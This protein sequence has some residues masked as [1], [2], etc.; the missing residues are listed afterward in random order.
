MNPFDH[1]EEMFD[2]SEFEEPELYESM[3]FLNA[4]QKP[5][6]SFEKKGKIFDL[7][8]SIKKEKI[9]TRAKRPS[10][11]LEKMMLVGNLTSSQQID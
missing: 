3:M 6:K 9:K 7:K 4:V 1:V 11:D 2:P 5:E 8:K 10:M